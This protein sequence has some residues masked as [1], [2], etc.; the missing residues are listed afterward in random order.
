M[1]IHGYH[2]MEKHLGDYGKIMFEV[3]NDVHEDTP[4]LFFSSFHKT[5][6]QKAML[7]FATLP[8]CR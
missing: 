6:K 7:L 3:F 4:V 1:E 8:F 5:P 2:E